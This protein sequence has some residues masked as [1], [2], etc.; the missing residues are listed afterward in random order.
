M[1]SN[2]DSER[3]CCITIYKEGDDVITFS[4]AEPKNHP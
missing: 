4:K 1:E 2:N 3:N